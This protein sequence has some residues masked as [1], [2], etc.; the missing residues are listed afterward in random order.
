MSASVQIDPGHDLP[1]TRN[2]RHRVAWRPGWAR[3][4]AQDA[5][6]VIVTTAVR[7]TEAPHCGRP[8]REGPQPNELSSMLAMAEDRAFRSRQARLVEASLLG[9]VSANV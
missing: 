2:R 3:P 6:K 4:G 7:D 8:T 5:T 1:V 9:Q